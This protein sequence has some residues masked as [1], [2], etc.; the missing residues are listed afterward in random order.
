MKK[1]VQNIYEKNEFLNTAHVENSDDS[2]YRII[3]GLHKHCSKI[4]NLIGVNIGV[5]FLFYRGRV[6][7]VGQSKSCV[8]SRILAHKKEG[9]LFDDYV[10]F[11]LVNDIAID[12]VEAFFI[13]KLNPFYNS[14]EPTYGKKDY[15][16]C[17]KYYMADMRKFEDLL[18]HLNIDYD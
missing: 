2:Y 7:Y 6:V 12:D 18:F 13:K 11:R 16:E 17:K 15:A 8:P 4:E 9:K 10:V 1:N 5:Y 3:Y 14:A